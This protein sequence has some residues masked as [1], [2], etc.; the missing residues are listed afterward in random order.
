[1]VLYTMDVQSAIV[2]DGSG[3][4]FS[5]RENI[6]VVDDGGMK[7]VLIKSTRECKWER[8]DR[9][10]KIMISAKPRVMKLNLPA[11]V[12]SLLELIWINSKLMMNTCT[13]ILKPE[14]VCN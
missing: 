9:L 11:R 6:R 14:I 10:E 2:E 5:T 1:M 13:S 12:T 4:P 8:L 7:R 3:E